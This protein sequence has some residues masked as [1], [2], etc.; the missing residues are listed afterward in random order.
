MLL[1]EIVHLPAIILLVMVVGAGT[2]LP[3]AIPYALGIGRSGNWGLAVGVI[4]GAAVSNLVVWF[5]FRAALRAAR[6]ANFLGFSR[7]V[8]LAGIALSYLA[9][10][11]QGIYL[12]AQFYL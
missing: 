10:L 9:G 4:V 7:S 11:G 5:S 2:T 3:T 12:L 1:P 6:T 8:W